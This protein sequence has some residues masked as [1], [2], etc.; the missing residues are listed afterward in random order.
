MGRSASA[1]A[2]DCQARRDRQPPC[3]RG[4]SHGVCH[5]LPPRCRAVICSAKPTGAAW[6]GRCEMKWTVRLL[7][8]LLVL[9]A[10]P[11]ARG[12][13]DKTKEQAQALAEIEK[14][15]GATLADPDHPGKPVV[16]VN[17]RFKEATDST[18]A[19]L[20]AFP[21]LKRLFVGGCPVTDDGL[22]NLKELTHLEQLELSHADPAE[23]R[24]ITDA[25]LAHLQGCAS[26]KDL[27]LVG[28]PVTD[29]G[30]PSLKRMTKLETLDLYGTKIT[31]NGLAQLKGLTNLRQLTLGNNPK[32][33]D[34]GLTPLKG[35][36]NLRDLDV[37]R[38][39]VTDA[40]VKELQKTLPKVKIKH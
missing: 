22:A 26:M 28:R 3:G 27:R 1:A 4:R 19:H 2:A 15:G 38:T 12:Q 20:K 24:K 11:P 34:E 35:L 36:T 6:H 7:A 39:E 16:E 30:L 9:P 32:I 14:L 40:G 17:L 33:T 21:H 31:D 10:C 37:T 23:A 8:F 18:L 25:G 29:A 5:C 13:D